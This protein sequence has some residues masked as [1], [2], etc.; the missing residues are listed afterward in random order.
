MNKNDVVSEFLLERG[1][2]KPVVEAGLEG[3]VGQWEDLV[4][5]VEEGYEL[6]LDDYLNDLDV[7]QLL[8][9]ALMLAN[10]QPDKKL[11]DRTQRADEQ[12]RALTQ[13]TETCLWGEEVAEEEGW[14]A[15]NNF[16]YFRRPRQ[17]DADFLAEI[18]E[19][20]GDE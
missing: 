16:W 1:C 20:L 18:S 14:T 11:A 9:A 10:V 19:A 6:G 4:S 2:A 17:G 12:F 5:A 15:K 3:L 8:A 7:R 13:A